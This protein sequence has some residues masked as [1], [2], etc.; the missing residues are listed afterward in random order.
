MTRPGPFG[1]DPVQTGP[2]NIPKEIPLRWNDR[3][4]IKFPAGQPVI[5]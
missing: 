5:C 4:K 1:D 3:E 2:V